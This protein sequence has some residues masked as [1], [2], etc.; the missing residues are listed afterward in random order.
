MKQQYE[1]R[2]L[3]TEF[4]TRTQGDKLIIEGYALKWNTPSQNLGGFREEIAPGATTKTIGEADIR[5]LINHD[6]NLILGRNRSGTLKLA[7]DGTGLFYEVEGDI[8]QSYVKDLAIAMERG[9]VSQSSFGFRTIDDSWALDDSD[10]PRRTLQQI[11]LHDV[12]PVT[13]PA[14]LDSTSG[15]GSRAL[16]RF[17]EQRGLDLSGGIDIA[18]VIRGDVEEPSAELDE[19]RS[20][21]TPLIVPEIDSAFELEIRARLMRLNG[22]R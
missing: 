15:L 17:A 13:Y 19:A 10:F 9:D 7:E 3:A 11:A 5:A 12:S 20:E 2:F 6:P 21:T 14:Y 8:R 4:E 1:R 18:A 22:S 16:E